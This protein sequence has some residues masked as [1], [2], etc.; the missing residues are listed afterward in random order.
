[1]EQCGTELTEATLEMEETLDEEILSKHEGDK[2]EITIEEESSERDQ[3]TEGKGR[4][5]RTFY[6]AR[7]AYKVMCSCNDEKPVH[8]GEL[9]DD[10]QASGMDECF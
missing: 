3:R 2:H 4:G 7:L 1:C 5:L 8:E 6:G 9:Y 10:I